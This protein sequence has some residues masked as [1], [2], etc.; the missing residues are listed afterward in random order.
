MKYLG[1]ALIILLLAGCDGVNYKRGSGDMITREF[2]IDNAE[3]INIYG[4]FQV[5][6]EEGRHLS[7]WGIYSPSFLAMMFF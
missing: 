4:Q 5:V 3:K 1:I 6:L 7:T 2:S